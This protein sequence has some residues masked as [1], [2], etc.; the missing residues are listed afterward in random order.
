MSDRLDRWGLLVCLVSR[1]QRESDNV[2]LLELRDVMPVASMIRSLVKSLGCVPKWLTSNK[3][4]EHLS[5]GKMAA[6]SIE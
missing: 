3:D 4:D 1:G 2:D 6:K 5:C